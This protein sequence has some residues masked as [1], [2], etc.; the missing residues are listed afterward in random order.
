MGFQALTLIFWDR[1]D[2]W[3]SRGQVGSAFGGPNLLCSL[4]F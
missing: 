2:H 1:G 3:M 4:Y